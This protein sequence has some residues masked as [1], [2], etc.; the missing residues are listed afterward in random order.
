MQWAP[1]IKGES[2][3]RS[4]L[5]SLSVTFKLALNG[6]RPTQSLRHQHARNHQPTAD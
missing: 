6:A 2:Y 4:P 3:R 5:E 1:S